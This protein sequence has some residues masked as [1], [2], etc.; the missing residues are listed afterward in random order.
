MQIS[1]DWDSSHIWPLLSTILGLSTGFCLNTMNS[2]G[3]KSFKWTKKQDR[4][5]TYFFLPRTSLKHVK[6]YMWYYYEGK[7]RANIL[8]YIINQIIW[9]GNIFPNHI[10]I[11][12]IILKH[13]EKGRSW[14]CL[15]TM[16]TK[17]AEVTAYRLLF[18]NSSLF[19]LVWHW[20]SGRIKPRYLRSS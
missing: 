9:N 3:V 4:T 16:C 7:C 10:V 8:F 2:I 11:F 18:S 5:L 1:V 12:L 19:V 6:L 20:Q 17:S 13:R 15:S 14:R